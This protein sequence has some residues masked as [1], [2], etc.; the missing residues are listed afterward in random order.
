MKSIL[1][2][3]HSH[4]KGQEVTSPACAGTSTETAMAGAECTGKAAGKEVSKVTPEPEQRGLHGR[5]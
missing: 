3:W 5:L 2:E 1:P 4:S